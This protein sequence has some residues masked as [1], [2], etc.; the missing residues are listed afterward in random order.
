MPDPLFSEVASQSAKSP[1]V[2]TLMADLARRC[3]RFERQKAEFTVQIQDNRSRREGKPVKFSKA[4]LEFMREADEAAGKAR[5]ETPALVAQLGD[6]SIVRSALNEWEM[7]A[8]FHRPEVYHD[9]DRA[10]AEQIARR[11]RD[12]VRFI[13]Q[14]CRSQGIQLAKPLR[15]RGISFLTSFQRAV[16]GI[17]KLG[18]DCMAIEPV[19]DQLDTLARKIDLPP[20]SRFVNHD[21]ERISGQKRE[22]FDPTS[23]LTTIRGLSG[24]LLKSSRKVKNTKQVMRDLLALETELASATERGV[25]F[26]FVMLD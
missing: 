20:P 23:G 17:A 11:I 12:T 16:P 24:Q 25:K 10:L 2:Q 3:H 26:C 4:A 9:D 7:E 6:E 21:P 19:L 8:D 1:E 15:H 14:F 5:Q 13:K 18:G 22:W